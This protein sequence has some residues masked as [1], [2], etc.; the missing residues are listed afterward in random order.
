MAL[1]DVSQALWAERELLE[2]LLFKLEEERA[3]VRSGNTRWINR[4]IEEIR[5]VMVR[6][7]EAE[8]ARRELWI[9]VAHQLGL[10]SEAS[11]KDLISRMAFPWDSIFNE[12][13]RALSQ[14]A[15]EC[16][17]TAVDDDDRLADTGAIELTRRLRWLSPQ[18]ASAA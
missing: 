12:H 16:Q 4:C 10:D 6:L 9:D 3:L 8:E 5:T 17:T 7:E 2:Q 15:R 1:K 13:Q 14:A 18:G 11:L